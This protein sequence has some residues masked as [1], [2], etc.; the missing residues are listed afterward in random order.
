ME[1]IVAT[2]KC[3]TQNIIS[4]FF[5]GISMSFQFGPINDSNN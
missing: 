4:G 1:V 2:S 5:L 3:K